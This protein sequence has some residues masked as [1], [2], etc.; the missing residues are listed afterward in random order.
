VLSV[1]LP[2]GLLAVVGLML[3]ASMATGRSVA[4][5]FHQDEFEQG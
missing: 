3:Q 4:S 5:H 2:V 1:V